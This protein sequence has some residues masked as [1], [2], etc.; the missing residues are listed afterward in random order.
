MHSLV[1][2]ES[3]KVMR[4]ILRFRQN[5]EAVE[6][7]EH[8]SIPLVY[9][10]VVKMAVYAYFLLSLVGCQTAGNDRDEV[11]LFF[12]LFTVFKLV[13]FVGWLKVAADLEKPFG[14]D[15]TD[16]DVN[17][18]LNRHLQVK[19]PRKRRNQL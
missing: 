17:A 7:H 11:D 4:E 10:L 8:V 12:P 15:D 5:L 1:P 18:L 13:L 3:G 2:T 19:C 9:K 6:S 14:E 16:F